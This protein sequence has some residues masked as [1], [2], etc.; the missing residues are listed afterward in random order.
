MADVLHWSTQMYVRVQNIFSF[1]A[2]LHYF[3]THETLHKCEYCN[4]HRT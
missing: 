4:E 2:L 1:T 3:E